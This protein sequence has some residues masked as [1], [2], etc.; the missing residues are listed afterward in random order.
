[1]KSRR[2]VIAIILFII[3]CLF[4]LM[5]YLL[6]SM[7]GEDVI[8]SGMSSE[9]SLPEIL[10][11]VYFYIPRIG[12]FITWPVATILSYQTSFGLDLLVRLIDVAAVITIIY[13]ITFLVL[14]RKPQL[15]LRDAGIFNIIFLLLVLIPQLISP[16]FGNPF[17]SG[18]SFIHN[19]VVMSLVAILFVMPF[20]APL[21]GVK[22]EFKVLKNPWVIF[23]LGFLF[24]ISTEL[25]PFSFLGVVILYLLYLKFIKHEK[26][27]ITKWQVFAVIGIV[28]G[29]GFFY[30]GGGL[31]T[32]TGFTYAETYNYVSL[33]TLF[34]APRYFLTT[35][36]SHFTSN[37]KYII[38]IIC[39]SLLSTVAYR[40]KRGKNTT[41]VVKLFV[42]M[43][44]FSLIYVVGASLILL[45]D[46]IT[47]RFLLPCY[48]LFITTIGLFITDFYKTLIN[49]RTGELIVLI[50]LMLFSV[51][52]ISDMMLGKI[53]Y[54]IRTNA[55]LSEIRE[56]IDNSSDEE[57]CLT[58]LWASSEA[59][60]V[61]SPIF[62]FTQE[63]IF[64]PWNVKRIYGYEIDWAELGEE[65]RCE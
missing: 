16:Y 60:P 52:V 43:D 2:K 64:E 7:S 18:F 42:L 65:D 6:M 26:I 30:L 37:I 3:P 21:I 19:Y 58:K 15:C 20:A 25:L 47:V 57:I 35:Y 45:D 63:P 5:A 8:Q 41:S 12:E 46:A 50:T 36:L 56:K 44:I 33:S 55:Q 59:G 28:A 11:W 14:R 39:F 38:P 40:V 32:R 24:A 9:K 23:V 49:S 53:K 61:Y 54:A 31:S 4:F 27:S 51:I 22:S 29:L 48:L 34:E 10:S 62:S 1:M 13:L 17:L